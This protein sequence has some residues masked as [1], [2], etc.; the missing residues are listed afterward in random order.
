MLTFNLN[1]EIIYKMKNEIFIKIYRVIHSCINNRQL[2]YAHKYLDMAESNGYIDPEF[3][4]AIYYNIYL[5]KKRE[6][7]NNAP[8]A[9]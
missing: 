8:L 6:L 4:Q 1:R 7:D 5:N 2:Y 3:R 9:E